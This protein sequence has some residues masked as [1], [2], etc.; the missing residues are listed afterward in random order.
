MTHT[1][2]HTYVAFADPHLVCDLCRQPVTRWHDPAQCGCGLPG[3]WNAPCGHH[4]GATSTC[5]SWSP[6]DGCR[7]LAH[8]GH[9]PHAPA[10]T[11]QS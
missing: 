10:T 5:P 4:A 11:P 7:C 9:V 1:R 6:V 3:W 2:V 8:L